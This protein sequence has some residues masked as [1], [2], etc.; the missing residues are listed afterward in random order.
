MVPLQGL[1]RAAPSL[2]CGGSGMRTQHG[3]ECGVHALQ[4]P[5][6]SAAMCLSIM[7]KKTYINMYIFV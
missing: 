7:T 5:K 1:L 4:Q 2:F 6:T 3:D